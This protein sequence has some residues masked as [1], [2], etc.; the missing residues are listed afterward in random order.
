MNTRTSFEDMPFEDLHDALNEVDELLEH[1]SNRFSIDNLALSKRYGDFNLKVGLVF[2]VWI[3]TEPVT[4]YYIAV[5]EKVP[6][7]RGLKKKER[8]FDGR[9][10][11]GLKLQSYTGVTGSDRYDD[12]VLIEDIELVNTP[13][14]VIP[15]FVRLQPLHNANGIAGCSLEVATDFVLK[16]LFG[17]SYW[18]ISIFERPGACGSIM[19]GK[20]CSEIVERRSEIVDDVP[21][22]TAPVLGGMALLK[23]MR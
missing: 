12:G 17:G 2:S 16:N 15:S 4:K 13:E 19:L 8:E 5:F 23:R 22:D 21:D 1:W 14:D 6:I 3:G 11:H 7:G 20:S 18:E 10:E 9:G